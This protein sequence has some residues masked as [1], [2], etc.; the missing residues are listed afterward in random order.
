MVYSVLGGVGP[1]AAA[2]P[3]AL[4]SGM[5][6]LASDPVDDRLK[7]AWL[8]SV[9]W[10][11]PRRV[12]QTP[13]HGRVFR[14]PGV[15]M[16]KRHRNTRRSRVTVPADL[17]PPKGLGFGLGSGLGLGWSSST[18]KVEIDDTRPAQKFCAGCRI[19][20]RMQMHIAGA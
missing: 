17:E 7:L 20:C 14:P 19:W 13:Q 12:G 3:V 15:F 8:A 18:C 10:S 16:E 9:S 2:A 5:T 6:D 1:R 4:L 11:M